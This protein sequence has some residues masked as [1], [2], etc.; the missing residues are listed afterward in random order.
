M[1]ELWTAGAVKRRLAYDIHG[2]CYCSDAIDSTVA[3]YYSR[4]NYLLSKK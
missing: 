1:W 4:I 2:V 3:W